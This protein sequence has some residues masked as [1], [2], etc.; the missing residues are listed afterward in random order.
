MALLVPHLIPGTLQREQAQL[1]QAHSHCKWS[2]SEHLGGTHLNFFQFVN[3]L[4]AFEVQE[5]E[6]KKHN[7]CPLSAGYVLIHTVQ[8]S[9]GFY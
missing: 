8:D 4:T 7:H 9:D 6:S 1:T 2:S 3:V 5:L